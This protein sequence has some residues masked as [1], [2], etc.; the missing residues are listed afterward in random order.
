MPVKDF[1]GYTFVAFM[2]ISGFKEMM[3]DRNQAIKALDGLY[4]TGFDV[5]QYN[6]DINGFFI[7]DSGILF[8][9]NIRVPMKQQLQSL[10]NVIENINRRLLAE[11][12]MLTTSISYGFFSYHKR[13]EV[14]GIEKN[15]IYG[16]AYVEAFLDNENGRPKIQPGE[17]RILLSEELNN[18]IE[19]IEKLKRERNHFYFYW[20]VDHEREIDNFK[21][22]YNNAYKLKYAGM[23]GALKQYGLTNR[24]T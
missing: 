8:V 4:K 10:L 21:K 1:S 13:I 24:S 23:L 5:L 15:P 16:N 7:S 14:V 22:E 2:D 9:R 11:D 12:I 18:D 6:D 3:K 20:M 17:C 19:N